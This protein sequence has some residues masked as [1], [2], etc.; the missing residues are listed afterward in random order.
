MHIVLFHFDIFPEATVFF[1]FFFYP[2]KSFDVD[3]LEI[4]LSPEKKTSRHGNS[5]KCK[6]C[7][8]LQ[9]PTLVRVLKV[10][11]YIL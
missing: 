2:S 6:K 5:S 10:Y 1:F 7:G 8:Q 3:L 9:F 4:F 11:P